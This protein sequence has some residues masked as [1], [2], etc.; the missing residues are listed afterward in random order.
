MNKIHELKDQIIKLSRNGVGNLGE[1]IVA[2]YLKGYYQCV[3]FKHKDLIDIQADGENIDVKTRRDLNK[4]YRGENSLPYKGKRLRPNDVTY[5]HLI[6]FQD[7]IVLSDDSKVLKKWKW[8][9][10]LNIV[11]YKRKTTDCLYWSTWS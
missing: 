3:E 4:K 6:F 1:N 11:S 8:E 5:L 9:Q 2:S 7:A 10:V